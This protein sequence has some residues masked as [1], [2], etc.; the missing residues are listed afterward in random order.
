MH[1]TWSRS[2]CSSTTTT[3][4]SKVSYM[5]LGARSVRRPARAS[6]TPPAAS[7]G[8]ITAQIRDASTHAVRR[9]GSTIMAT[10]SMLQMHSRVTTVDVPEACGSLASLAASSNYQLGEHMGW[11]AAKTS[12]E[13]ST[14]WSLDQAPV[15][16]GSHDT[17]RQRELENLSRVQGRASAPPRYAHAR[18]PALTRPTTLPI[19]QTMGLPRR[20][21]AG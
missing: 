8:L 11:P 17:S 2:W 10:A 21:Q 18:L 9:S 14:N 16:G 5:F 15:A 13:T 20:D 3:L 12:I 7:Q 4:F 1:I 6:R 19:R